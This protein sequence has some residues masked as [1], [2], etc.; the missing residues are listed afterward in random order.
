MKSYKT[1]LKISKI[2]FFFSILSVI[3]GCG[4]NHDSSHRSIQSDIVYI[5]TEF[6]GTD[7]QEPKKNYTSD[8]LPPVVLF[9]HGFGGRVNASDFTQEMQELFGLFDKFQIN[10]ETYTWNSKEFN[11]INVIKQWPLANKEAKKEADYFL[12]Y[13][14]KFESRGRPYYLIGYSLGTKVVSIA[15]QK[16]N[17]KLSNLKGLYFIG[18]AIPQNMKI[19]SENLPEGL[20]IINFFSPKYDKTLANLYTIKGLKTKIDGQL[21]GGQVGFDDHS[22][23]KNLKTDASHS[24]DDDD[25][26]FLNMGNSIGYLIA[27]N[28]GYSLSNYDESKFPINI[29]NTCNS[30]EKITNRWN[31]LIW[32]E[33]IVFQQN[34]CGS[35]VNYF[36]TK[37]MKQR[38]EKE[39]KSCNLHKLISIY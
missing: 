10:V 23:F 37:S 34:S 31:N 24:P 19:P 8:T 13:I 16:A 29:I 11:V 26:N 3:V 14:T 35:H 20:K 28:E 32:D 22:I 9:V 21:A 4:D 15:L 1:M 25:C 17:L 2:C 5:W 6:F 39:G 36:R 30:P 12:E 18:A 33:D 27:I 7:K 38:K